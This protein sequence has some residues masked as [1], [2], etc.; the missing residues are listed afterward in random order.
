MKTPIGR[1]V[2]DRCIQVNGDT[3]LEEIVP[4]YDD[5][6]DAGDYLPSE[7]EGRMVYVDE[8][9]VHDLRLMLQTFRVCMMI[10]PLA[11]DQIEARLA[12]Y[13]GEDNVHSE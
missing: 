3:G 5:G 1:T 7:T 4:I 6:S 13:E 11:A 10:N 8:Q 2:I 9:L 12:E